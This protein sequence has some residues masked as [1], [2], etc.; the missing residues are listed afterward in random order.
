MRTIMGSLLLLGVF[1]FPLERITCPIVHRYLR[2]YAIQKLTRMDPVFH[3]YVRIKTRPLITHPL[4][5]E[6]GNHLRGKI[7]ASFV[8]DTL[9]F[10][11]SLDPLD[12]LCPLSRSIEDTVYESAEANQKDLG[13]FVKHLAIQV[14]T[15]QV[16]D[17]IHDALTH[18][19]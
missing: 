1:G 19:G 9:G 11:E 13:Y 6:L 12:P 3:R 14:V 16:S 17:Y 15:H 8:P 10:V 7:A 18:T 4:S 5:R 2:I